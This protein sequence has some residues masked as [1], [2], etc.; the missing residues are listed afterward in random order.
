MQTHQVLCNDVQFLLAGGRLKERDI[1]S[2]CSQQDSAKLL[3]KSKASN[4]CILTSWY[5]A[6]HILGKL[7]RWNIPRWNCMFGWII[8]SHLEYSWMLW[9]RYTMREQC[10][11]ML[12]CLQNRQMSKARSR[13]LVCGMRNDLLLCKD[14]GDFVLLEVQGLIIPGQKAQCLFRWTC[15]CELD[16]KQCGELVKKKCWKPRNGGHRCTSE[17]HI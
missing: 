5:G 9:K 2:V 1:R 14:W 12:S 15:K 11:N 10:A 8:L 6:F 17:T 13:A 7:G 16:K 3:A 4:Q